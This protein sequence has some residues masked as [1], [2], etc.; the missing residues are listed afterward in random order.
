MTDN[1]RRAD[2]DNPR[3]Y[4]EF[5]RVKELLTDRSWVPEARGKAV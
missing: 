5:E 4:Y 2:E 1:I 3:G